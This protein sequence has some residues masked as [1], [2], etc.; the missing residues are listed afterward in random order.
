VEDPEEVG[1]TK[2]EVLETV[3]KE[4]TVVCIHVE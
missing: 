3:T 1:V 4:E 2:D